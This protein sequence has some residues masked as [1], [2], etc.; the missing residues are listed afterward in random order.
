MR[1]VIAIFT[2]LVSVFFV[3]WFGRMLFVTGLLQHIRPGGREVA[4]RFSRGF[5]RHAAK[6][7]S[8]TVLPGPFGAML[9]HAGAHVG[10]DDGPRRTRRCQSSA[11]T[12]KPMR[13]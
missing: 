4:R 12:T 3:F 7:G 8:H 9:L 10:R 1:R 6:V 11:T 13:G 2:G 5:A